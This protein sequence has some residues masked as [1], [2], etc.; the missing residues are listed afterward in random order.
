MPI[1]EYTRAMARAATTS[2]VFNAVAEPRR[3]QILTLL[4]KRE[5]SVNELAKS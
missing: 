2:D 1:W 4:Q 3:L 5:R